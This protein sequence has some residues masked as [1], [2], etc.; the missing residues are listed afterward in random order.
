MKRGIRPPAP[1][2]AAAISFAA[3]LAGAAALPACATEACSDRD[4]HRLSHL[5]DLVLA[6]PGPTADA[7]EEALVAAGP[8]A[9]LHVE[10]GFYDAEPSGRRRLVEVLTRI[11]DPAALPILAHLAATDPDPDVR[12]DAAG[13]ARALEGGPLP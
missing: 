5:V 6:E 2:R 3:W 7:A 9:I 11:G 4:E 10:T 12:S 8:P 13:G 1:R